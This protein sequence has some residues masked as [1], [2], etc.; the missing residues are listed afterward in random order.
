MNT[1]RDC[2]AQT[3]EASVSCRLALKL[4]ADGIPEWTPPKHVDRA[5]TPLINTRI[6]AAHPTRAGAA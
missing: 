1:P 4:D 3:A 5:Q 6:L 2:G